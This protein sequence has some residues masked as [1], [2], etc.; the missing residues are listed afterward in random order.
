MT[1]VYWAAF[2]A[3][4]GLA[5]V[6][7]LR[8]GARRETSAGFGPLLGPLRLVLVAVVLVVAASA[9]HLFAAAVGWGAAFVIAF[10]FAFWRWS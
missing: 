4:A 7:L 1:P 2:G 10:N 3:L 8:R 9:G 5:Q 6:A